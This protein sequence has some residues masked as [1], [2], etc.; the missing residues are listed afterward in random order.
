MIMSSFILRAVAFPAIYLA[1]LSVSSA[2]STDGSKKTVDQVISMLKTMDESQR[3]QIIKELQRARKRPSDNS[4]AKGGNLKKPDVAVVELSPVAEPAT[5]IRPLTLV[6]ALSRRNVTADNVFNGCRGFVPLLRKDWKDIDFATCPQSIDK[7]S[8][9]EISFSGDRV[10]K[11]TTWV[12]DGTS[13][14][15]Y[16]FAGGG[17]VMSTGGYV[18]VNR[19][20]NSSIKESDNNADKV[21][22]GGVF[23]FGTSA[24]NNPYFANYFR[25]RGGGVE[26]N[27]KQTNS[28]NV[29]FEWLPVYEDHSFI[30]LH[31]PFNPIPDLPLILRLDPS[32]LVQYASTMGG[33][34]SLAFN[35]MDQ[36]L[37]VGPQLILRLYPGTSEFLSHFVGSVSYHWA[38]ETYSSRSVSLF[39]STLTYNIDKAGYIGL[40]GSY[41]RGNDEDTGVKSDLYK[42]SLTGK[43]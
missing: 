3:E 13:A 18:T 34:K 14:L 41:Q 20:S 32:L 9:A 28:G 42:I 33:I 40:T 19:T 23:E 37:R 17:Y 4:Q 1:L 7:A 27:I 31:S 16:N 5:S 43:I 15:L 38:Y 10:K 2:Q 8:G 12:V 26:D 30:H 24:S 22:Y 39:Q 11:N 35:N 36:A 29:T 21:A 25:V 6:P